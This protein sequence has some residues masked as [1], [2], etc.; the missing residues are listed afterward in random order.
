MDRLKLIPYHHKLVKLELF[1]VVEWGGRL[2]VTPDGFE[3]IGH[4]HQL[5]ECFL[6]IHLI[7]CDQ[8]PKELKDYLDIQYNLIK[9][10]ESIEKINL[11]LYL[12]YPMQFSLLAE[13]LKENP[14]PISKPLV[15][16]QTLRSPGADLLW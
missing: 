6:G 11:P 4:I 13:L 1:Q 8:A 2:P 12:G 10:V 5:Y 16:V 9:S 14:L 15:P 7:A 3:I